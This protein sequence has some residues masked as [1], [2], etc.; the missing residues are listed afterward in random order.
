MSSREALNQSNR[1]GQTTS[2]A[3]DL[4]IRAFG[5]FGGATG[6]MTAPPVIKSPSAFYLGRDFTGATMYRVGYTDAAG[7]RRVHTVTY[8]AQ[9]KRIG[10]P[11]LSGATGG[12][13]APGDNL[14]VGGGDPRARLRAVQD[15]WVKW[16]ALNDHLSATD[17]AGFTRQIRDWKGTPAELVKHMQFIEANIPVSAVAVA[18]WQYDM[19]DFDMGGGGGGG[20][21]FAGPVYEAPDR[22]VVEDYVRGVLVGLVGNIPDEGYVQEFTDVYMKDHRKDFDT[23]DRVIDPSQSVVEAVRRTNEYQTI[24][25][26]RPESEDERSWVATRR[27]AAEQGGLNTDLQ[28]DFAINQA[29]IGGDVQDVRRAAAVTQLQSTGQAPSILDNQFR[30]IANSMFQAVRR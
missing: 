1:S 13:G 9:K 21:G 10:K 8:D 26:L 22:R 30:E 11:K 29:T 27:G 5:M 28:E 18:D 23:P 25:K 14:Q 15:S 6:R 2:F 7:R 20:G 3:Y 19:G 24:H 12:I 16:V 17:K 4:A